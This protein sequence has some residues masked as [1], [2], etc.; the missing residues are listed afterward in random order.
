MKPVAKFLSVVVAL[1][2]SGTA[3]ILLSFHMDATRFEQL[4]QVL[5]APVRLYYLNRLF[6]EPTEDCFNCYS[7][8]IGAMQALEKNAL[9]HGQDYGF[10]FARLLPL[11]RQGKGYIREPVS[12]MACSLILK[13]PDERVYKTMAQ[14]F[15]QDPKSLHAC[16]VNYASNFKKFHPAEYEL[17][18]N[19]MLKDPALA[20][21][22]SEPN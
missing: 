11:L 3:Y 1:A 20:V 13:Y 7:Q 21:Y 16:L 22:A 14:S 12:V 17:A 10:D 9:E 5:P 2:L 6:D 18:H 19:T 8:L 15:S 4:V